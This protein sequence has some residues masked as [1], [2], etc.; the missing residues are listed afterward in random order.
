MTK[1]P[2][3]RHSPSLPPAQSD[4][5]WRIPTRLWQLLKRCADDTYLY[6]LIFR[7]RIRPW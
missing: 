4:G 7:D 6:A 1:A 3:Q 2:P 5:L